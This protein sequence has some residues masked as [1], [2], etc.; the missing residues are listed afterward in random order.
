MFA[1]PQHVIKLFS[2]Y[3]ALSEEAPLKSVF[4]GDEWS[5]WKVWP[6]EPSVRFER[7]DD[8]WDRVLLQKQNLHDPGSAYAGGLK[9]IHLVMLP[10]TKIAKMATFVDAAVH[11]ESQRE[12]MVDVFSRAKKVVQHTKKA[13]Q[14]NF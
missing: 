8:W 4:E 7:S 2:Y 5:A 9:R 14:R 13:E 1:L 12:N 3:T 6:R 10:K 11:E